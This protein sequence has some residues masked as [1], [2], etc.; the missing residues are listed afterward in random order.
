M[1]NLINR[2]TY[3]SKIRP[4]YD[5]DIIKVI[6]GIRRSGKSF[7]LKSIINEIKSKG[8]NID[9]II[10]I[11][12]EDIDFAYI[13]NAIDL[14]KEIKSKI[15]D[16]EKYFVFLDEIQYVQEF[17][18]ALASIKA[19]CNVSLFVTGSN[20]TLLSGKL[21]SLLTGRTIEFEVFPFSYFEAVEYLHVNN[22]SSNALTIENY[23]KC[24]GFPFT[25]QLNSS[26]EVINYVK[27][28]YESIVAKDIAHPY[29]R[30]DRSLFNTVALYIL[31]NAGK[32]LSLAN[33]VNYY[34]SHNTDNKLT[35]PMV[36]TF[37]D[38]MVQAY[39]IYPISQYNLSGKQSL[40]SH[41]KY[42][43]TD[44]ALRTIGT[45]TI[46]FEDTFFLENLICNELKSR[47][48]D[49]RTGK[50]YRSE[51][52]F[53]VILNGKK[54]FIQVC[55]YLLNEQTI[56]REFDAFNPIKDHS[57][58]YVLSLDKVDLS[59]N[60]IAHLNI[61]DFLLHKVDITLT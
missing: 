25:Y 60:G 21:A 52:D 36:K 45:N 50:T 26:Q 15:L 13:Q 8:V 54:C 7:L 55:Y 56:K 51:I 19:T 37:L 10:Y 12:F 11:N 20:S 53:I 42:Y 16:N 22:A 40:N 43:A 30:I 35:R 18:K 4:Y 32:D 47:G 34:N 58:K 31:A 23:L 44:L 14:N 59:H 38:K 33:I 5:L 49:V 3:L 61:E 29:S 6:T 39:L 48:Y 17:E 9:H 24:G 2:E 28:L 1:V 27:H 46:D 41:P 57:P